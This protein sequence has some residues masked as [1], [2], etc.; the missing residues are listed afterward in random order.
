MR[1]GGGGR[2]GSVA[3]KQCSFET[4]KKPL[5]H[6]FSQQPSLSCGQWG[7][8]ELCS[9]LAHCI[10]L[11]FQV[12]PR[13]LDDISMSLQHR[14]MHRDTDPDTPT[15]TL[16][17][18]IFELFS[19]WACFKEPTRPLCFTPCLRHLKRTCWD[20]VLQQQRSAHLNFSIKSIFWGVLPQISSLIN[21]GLATFKNP[22]SQYI[23]DSSMQYSDGNTS[24]E[25]NSISSF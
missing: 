22:L 8:E 2:I 20:S 16:Q 10:F 11:F 15:H 23:S 17:L 18:C 6:V 9:I 13:H 24:N 21:F 12:I 5:R 14:H 19:S 4:L 25:I 1:E 3:Y 7:E